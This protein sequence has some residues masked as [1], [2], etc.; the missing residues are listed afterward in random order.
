MRRTFAFILI[1]AL[2]VFTISCTR[3]VTVEKPGNMQVIVNGRVVD[4]V[5]DKSMI[6][7]INKAPTDQQAALIRDWIAAKERLATQVIS[8]EDK[9][10]GASGNLS[11]ES[12]R[13]WGRPPRVTSRRARDRRFK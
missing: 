12:L 1:L 6:E 5:S 10:T 8:S 2:V 4:I 3:R 11:S 13:S 9:N 7:V